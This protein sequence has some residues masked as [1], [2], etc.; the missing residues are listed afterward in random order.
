MDIMVYETKKCD[1]CF[2]N[3]AAYHTDIEGDNKILH[4]HLATCTRKSKAVSALD[5]LTISGDYC[6]LVLR[7]CD[8]CNLP[9][10]PC[11]ACLGIGFTSVNYESS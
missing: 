2:G 1:W 8:I 4:D 11:N 7:H 5:I 6:A 9:C 10:E 3:R